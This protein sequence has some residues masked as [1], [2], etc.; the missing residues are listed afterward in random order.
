MIPVVWYE[1]V[2]WYGCTKFLNQL[3]DTT[4]FVHPDFSFT[5]FLNAKEVPDT[6]EA[7]VVIHGDHQI[8]KVYDIQQYLKKFDRSIVINI[9]DENGWFPMD[10]LQ[11][12]GRKMWMQMPV[13]GKHDFCRRFILGYPPDAPS[14]I[15][16]LGGDKSHDWFFSGQIT[17]SHRQRCA[18]QLRTLTNGVLKETSGFFQGF[19]REEYYRQMN[20]AKVIPCPSGP[21][22]PDTFRVWEAL[23]SG[24]VPIVDA[25]CPKSGFPPYF[26]EYVFDEKPPFQLVHNWDCLP[27]L[28]EEQLKEWPHNAIKLSAWWQNYQSL[29]YSWLATDFYGLRRACI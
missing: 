6:E 11:A 1:G 29:A 25:S 22:T 3:F 21:V 2:R 8:S 28:I 4:P 23:E 12:S 24:C 26:W 27:D 15:Q 18:E 10:Q 17:H 7:V 9:G 19:G 14:Y 20:E 16:V 13:P 5:H